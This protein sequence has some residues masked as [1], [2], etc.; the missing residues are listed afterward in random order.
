MSDVSLLIIALL[1]V[2][3]LLRVDFIFYIVYVLAGIYLWSRWHTPRAFKK[4]RFGRAFA[5]HAFLG[6]RVTVTLT[7]RNKGRLP[8]P[9]VQLEESVPAELVI[10]QAPAHAVALR[11]KERATFTYEVQ[12]T[13]RGYYRLGPLYIQAG[14]LFG[15]TELQA[16]SAS[17]YLTVYPRIIPLS[18]LG[19]PSRLPFGTIAS[20]QRLFEDPARPV[21]VR[22]YRSGDSL[23]QINWKVSAHRA[24]TRGNH[25]MV[26][27]LQP[28]ISLD[29]ALLLNLNLEEYDR[30]H[31]WSA[32]EW[33][34]E[35]AASL[36]A[37][38]IEQQQ[39]VG[40]MTNGVD[41][42]LRA[43]GEEPAFDEASGRLLQAESAE[44][45]ATPPRI[46]PRTGRAHLMKVLERLARIEPRTTTPFPALIPQ[47]CHA[48]SW[49]VTIPTITPSGDEATCQALHRLV[50]AGFNPVLIVVTPT[51]RFGQ[52]RERARQL[53]FSAYHITGA[54]D[55][56]EW[57]QPLASG[58]IP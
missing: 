12:A 44:S 54:K 33:A 26:K 47:A 53:G 9:W 55:L 25:L 14:D 11:G 30:R 56:N 57:R 15:W 20:R 7:L 42:L 43:G 37:H 18:H 49:G 27:T 16:Q 39:A 38:L 13:R 34:I 22:E 31:R 8:V 32:P 10:G 40:L 51:H 48:L 36:A 28:A 52:I 4:I 2:A 23:R 41:P 3:A 45:P 35:V 19:L 21:G 5:D 50:R 58:V 24:G 17:G 29:T 1:L 6:E 46:P